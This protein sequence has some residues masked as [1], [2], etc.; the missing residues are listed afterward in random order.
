MRA[1]LWMTAAAA[2]AL[3]GLGGAAL[4]QSA[5][6]SS[7]QPQGAPYPSSIET[8]QNTPYAPGQ[9]TLDV[10]VTD[11]DRGVFQGARQRKCYFLE[12][13]ICQAKLFAIS[14]GFNQTHF[15]RET[16]KSV[17]KSGAY[18][19]VLSKIKHCKTADFRLSTS[20]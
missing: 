10:D 11:T 18:A 15:F 9:L 5:M 14:F 16:V 2:A 17:S 13:G 7:D 3:I 1:N 4:A 12:I 6:G 8:P 19:C 20:D